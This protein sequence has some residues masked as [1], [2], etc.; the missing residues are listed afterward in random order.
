[1]AKMM[2]VHDLDG[3]KIVLATL[4][5]NQIRLQVQLADRR[6]VSIHVLSDPEG[7]G[8]GS[9]HVLAPPL[10]FNDGKHETHHRELIG[11]LGGR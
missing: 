9:L 8:P 10:M 4:F 5:D 11:I 2:Q 6:T 3:A 1:M 7:N